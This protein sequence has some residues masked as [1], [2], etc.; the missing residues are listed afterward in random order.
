MNLD[1]LPDVQGIHYDG[2]GGASI[3]LKNNI[4]VSVGAPTNNTQSIRDLAQNE[5]SF[6][7]KLF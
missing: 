2:V 3:H 4:L 6:T 5:S 7:E 1:C